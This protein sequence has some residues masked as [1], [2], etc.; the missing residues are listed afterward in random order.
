MRISVTPCLRCLY[1]HVPLP[2]RV[3]LHGTPTCQ[4]FFMLDQLFSK[5]ASYLRRND[6]HDRNG[7]LRAVLDGF[8]APQYDHTPHVCNLDRAANIS[9]WITPYLGPT[10]N[11]TQF[12]QFKL[13]MRNGQVCVSARK[14]CADLAEFNEWESLDHTPGSGPT[15]VPPRI[16]CI[17]AI[18]TCVQYTDELGCAVGFHYSSTSCRFAAQSVPLATT[19]ARQQRT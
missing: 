8:S 15:P 16:T 2:I 6:A 3:H 1:A 17:M 18:L 4:I 7:I 11:L 5:I 13:E 9:E 19:Y 14:R 12:R 10:P